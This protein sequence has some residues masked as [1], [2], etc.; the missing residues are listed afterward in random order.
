VSE[1]D[2]CVFIQA[3]MSSRRFPGK[4]LAPFRG[5]P[6]I[7]W[8]IKRAR[9]G[10]R[11]APV[12]VLT[13][14]HVTDDPL[15]AYLE[16]CSQPLVR[17]PLDDVLRRFQL[18]LR[19]WPAQ[20]IMRLNADSP[21]LDPVVVSSVRAAMVPEADVITTTQPRTFPKG[22]NVEIVRAATLSALDG[23]DVTAHDREHVTAYLYRHPDRFRIVNVTSPAPSLAGLDYA[24][25]TV[26]DLH[27]LEAAPLYPMQQRDAA[28]PAVAS[29]KAG[30]A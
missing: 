12:V 8:L 20:W 10:A 3:R 15:V 7:D 25:D 24:I 26:D 19:A 21:L 30:R 29:A 14:T 13:S 1:P 16:T 22:Q 23:A 2:L 27:R 5:A 9:E 17:G 4:V 11:D 28:S 18:G 6:I